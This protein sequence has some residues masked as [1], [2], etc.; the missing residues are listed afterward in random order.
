MISTTTLAEAWTVAAAMLGENY[1]LDERSTERAG[2][3][4]YRSTENYYN[5][6]CDLGNRLEVNTGSKSKNICFA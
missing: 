1:E 3:P 5:Y 6:I 2:Y 4:V